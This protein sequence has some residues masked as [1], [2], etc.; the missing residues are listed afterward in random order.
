MEVLTKLKNAFQCFKKKFINPI[1]DYLHDYCANR[2]ITYLDHQER[3][4]YEIVEILD[5]PINERYIVYV[6]YIIA[7]YRMVDIYYSYY[8]IAM[9]CC[10]SVIACTKYFAKAHRD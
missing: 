7:A 4:R 8:N 1:G 6:S 3:T 10:T 9:W 5:F 2:Y